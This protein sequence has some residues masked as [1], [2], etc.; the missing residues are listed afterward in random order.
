MAMATGHNPTKAIGGKVIKEEKEKRNPE[1]H[2]FSKKT[3][4]GKNPINIETIMTQKPKLVTK[5]LINIVYH[6]FDEEVEDFVVLFDILNN[7]SSNKYV[8]QLT[9][10]A[11]T[12]MILGTIRIPEPVFPLIRG[13]EIYNKLND[14]NYKS[15]WLKMIIHNDVKFI[16]YSVAQTLQMIY[17]I[18]NGDE[19][20]N[21]STENENLKRLLDD[22]LRQEVPLGDRFRLEFLFLQMINLDNYT[23]KN[24][25]EIINRTFFT[26]RK[27]LSIPLTDEE[28]NTGD[29][30]FPRI[31]N[32][33]PGPKRFYKR[34]N[35]IV[36]KLKNNEQI[37]RRSQL[38]QELLEGYGIELTG[39]FYRISSNIEPIIY[40][41][42]LEYLKKY[43]Y[44][45]TITMKVLFMW[46]ITQK[47][48]RTKE[49]NE[50]PM[51]IDVDMEPGLDLNMNY[52]TD[53][54][55]E[56]II[57][58]NDAVSSS[59]PGM[60]IETPNQD[61]S[62]EVLDFDVDYSRPPQSPAPSNQSPLRE[63]ASLS[64]GRSPSPIRPREYQYYRPQ[65][66]YKNEYNVLGNA[67]IPPNL[68][69]S[70]NSN[71]FYQNQPAAAGL[72]QQQGTPSL[73][74]RLDTQLSPLPSPPPSP[75][76]VANV[77]TSTNTSSSRQRQPC[78]PEPQVEP[79]QQIRDPNID[80]RYPD[81]P[82]NKYYI[83]IESVD[84]PER[85]LDCDEDTKWTFLQY[86]NLSKYISSLKLPVYLLQKNED[87][88]TLQDLYKE[89]TNKNN[90]SDDGKKVLDKITFYLE[91]DIRNTR[92]IF[93]NMK[94][95]KRKMTA[96]VV[97]PSIRLTDRPLFYNY[98]KCRDTLK[99]YFGPMDIFM[100]EENTSDDEKKM[101]ITCFFLL[102]NESLNLVIK[103]VDLL[104][105]MNTRIYN[106]MTHYGIN[107][108]NYNQND[109]LSETK[110][111]TMIENDEKF[112][113]FYAFLLF[114]SN[115]MYE[116]SELYTDMEEAFN[117]TFNI[118]ASIFFGRKF[119][120]VKFLHTEIFRSGGYLKTASTTGG[121]P[122]IEDEE[123]ANYMLEK[124]AVVYALMFRINYENYTLQS[125]R[126]SEIEL[127][128]MNVVKKEKNQPLA[129]LRDNYIHFFF[130]HV[131]SQSKLNT[132]T[133]NQHKKAIPPHTPLNANEF[134]SI[135]AL[136]DDS[137][138]TN[139]GTIGKKCHSCSKKA[140]YCF[141][142]GN[143]LWNVC[144]KKCQLELLN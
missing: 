103:T 143:K 61:S 7:I 45:S 56:P 113:Q 79:S 102:F 53:L 92:E 73:Y 122:T 141:E 110:K 120:F 108:A 51:D 144:D 54:N 126:K 136:L 1:K 87:L 13:R 31:E 134:G 42:L 142:M 82:F 111:N 80:Y 135:L 85:A 33:V 81:P 38:N 105:K 41:T 49:T 48:I 23:K 95:I 129:I 97:S 62:Q 107:V 137:D 5:D 59:G 106:L 12:G 121:P 114:F 90:Q 127:Y 10:E 70:S 43:G 55:R 26:Y 101:I 93:Q 52:N 96:Y 123:F 86:P 17:K 37:E 36:N 139:Q 57:N 94:S 11:K 71:M 66:P 20:I 76:S 75:F 44:F 78:V 69:P 67:L 64:Q 132:L 98:T 100:A 60:D 2:G 3:G 27:L 131:G 140:K 18:I 24:I 6:G 104:F 21:W 125:R 68:L 133:I 46:E 84:T 47:S 28:K 16:S 9:V 128:K 119:S 40:D 116:Q 115:S 14:N 130:R 65:I 74:S 32:R 138:S 88:S 25:T 22:N 91:S 83:Y 29:P 39:L 72:N 35:D 8:D 124:M 63:S 89:L 30:D 34:L 50:N 77:D 109:V 19:L 58:L 118:V 99:Y 112:A 4:T 117:L 15:V